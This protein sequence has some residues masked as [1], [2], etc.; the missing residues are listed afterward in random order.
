M[1]VNDKRVPAAEQQG[2]LLVDGF[3]VPVA[4]VAII[5]TRDASWAHLSA[6]DCCARRIGGRKIWPHQWMLHKTIADDP[7]QIMHG[8][9]PAGRARRTAE[10]WEGDP[11][12]SGAHV[13][14]GLD[15][16]TA[17]LADLVRVMAYHGNLAN[18][19][20][21]G[22]ETCEL[23]GGGCHEAAYDAAVKVCVAGCRALGIQLQTFVLGTYANHP[24]ARM[25]NGGADVMGIVGHRDVTD[26]RGEWDPG[27]LLFEM[28]VAMGAEQ[29][30]FDAGEDLDIWKSRQ[31]D[32]NKRG[33]RLVVDGIPG[34]RTRDALAAEGYV[35]GI[36]AL[37]RSSFHA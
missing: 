6:G 20:A 18:I 10:Y 17:C 14:T 22:H 24:R 23:V 37:G 11:K 33:H 8:S 4:G 27:N 31:T 28:L 2:G 3:E 35:D 19:W 9:G 29:F 25:R 12:H 15:G 34:L 32:L 13:V 1:N 21:V 16:E 26:S 7:E 5:S 36:F 30:D